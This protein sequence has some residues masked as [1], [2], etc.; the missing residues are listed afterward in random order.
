MPERFFQEYLGGEDAFKA[1]MEYVDAGTTNW[2]QTIS[3][4][5]KADVQFVYL[6][7]R[8]KVQLRLT[9]LKF[10]KNISKTFCGE[11]T[12][13]NKNWAVLCG[14]VVWAEGDFPQRG[15]QGFR[16]TEFIF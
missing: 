16:Y 14:P 6:C 11:R 13:N 12:F 15:F 2:N 5:P 8:G 9:L 4:V 7:Y 3:S 10:E 1:V